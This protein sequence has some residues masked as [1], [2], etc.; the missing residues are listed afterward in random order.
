MD[1]PTYKHTILVVNVVFIIPA[2]VSNRKNDGK[3]ESNRNHKQLIWLAHY[4]IV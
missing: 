2:T 4:F 3:T 1:F